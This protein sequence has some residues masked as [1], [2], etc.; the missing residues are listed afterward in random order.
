M[1]VRYVREGEGPAVL[2]LHGLGASLAVW[3]ETIAPIARGN[4]VYALDL[5]GHGRSDKREEIEYDAIAGAHFLVQYMNSLGISTASLIGNSAGGLVTAIC[6]ILYP[7]RIDRCWST[8]LAWA[9][10]WHGFFAWRRFPSSEN[11]S[12]CQTS[13]MRET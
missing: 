11:C 7:Q 10:K 4:A 13:A 12:T 3:G 6:A 9:G 8:L 2:L 1:K 5:P